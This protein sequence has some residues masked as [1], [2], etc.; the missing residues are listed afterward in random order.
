[1]LGVAKPPPLRVLSYK[2]DGDAC[3]KIRITPLKETNLGMAQVLKETHLNPQH[4]LSY[5]DTVADPDLQIRGSGHPG[6]EIRVWWGGGGL[7]KKFF[8]AL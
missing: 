6:P 7:L 4:F 3:W 5:R 2:H 1:M 8:S